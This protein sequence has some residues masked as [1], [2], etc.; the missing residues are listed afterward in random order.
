M[1]SPFVPVPPELITLAEAAE[2][3][4]V[5]Q[6]TL[7]AFFGQGRGRPTWLKRWLSANGKRLSRPTTI[8]RILKDGKRGRLAYVKLDDI[9]LIE[10]ARADSRK[11][12]LP[13]QVIHKGEVCLSVPEFARRSGMNV[14]TVYYRVRRG[15]LPAVRKRLK[16]PGSGG[17]VAAIYVPI[18]Q[19]AP[20]T[21]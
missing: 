21:N 20:C 17:S 10:R 2:R 8:L 7:R 4:N 16:R 3:L 19:L 18:S 9:R 15:T 13:V 5:N 11:H 6:S 1:P 14:N 12:T